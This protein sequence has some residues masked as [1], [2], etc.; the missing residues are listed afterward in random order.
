MSA[1]QEFSVAD[2]HQYDRRT[3]LRW[4]ARYRDVFGA[5]AIESVSLDFRRNLPIGSIGANASLGKLTLDLD[6]R[7]EVCVVVGRQRD[8]SVNLGSIG[9]IGGG[10]LTLDLR[11]TAFQRN[12]DDLVVTWAFQLGSA[13]HK[14]SLGGSVLERAISRA[15]SRK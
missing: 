15:T 6:G 5:G 1:I 12:G 2:A 7:A 8:C 4:V 10:A 11:R 9:S 14:M 13:M 3:P